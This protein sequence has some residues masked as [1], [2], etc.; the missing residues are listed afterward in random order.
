MPAK[1]ARGGVVEADDHPIAILVRVEGDL[2]LA[3]P[4]ILSHGLGVACGGAEAP[5]GRLLL[6]SGWPPPPGSGGLS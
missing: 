5:R 3:E 1:K 2:H 6:S 4:A